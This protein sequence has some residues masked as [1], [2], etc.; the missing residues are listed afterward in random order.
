MEGICGKL[1]NEENEWN[2]GILGGVKE[3]PADCTR[4]D[5]VV[6]ALKKD[7]KV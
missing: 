1:M 5:E 4:I 7:K 6:A 3:G 2:H